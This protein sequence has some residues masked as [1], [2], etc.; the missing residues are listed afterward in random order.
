[1]GGFFKNMLQM[2]AT[3]AATAFGGPLAGAAMSGGLGMA[4]SLLKGGSF[5]EALI[6]GAT[7]A[8]G[9]ALGGGLAEGMSAY[10]ASKAPDLVTMPSFV[11]DFSKFGSDPSNSLLNALKFNYK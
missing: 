8:V 9:P 2:G 11:P 10:N 1:M 4:D 3:G 7:G 5:G 6:G